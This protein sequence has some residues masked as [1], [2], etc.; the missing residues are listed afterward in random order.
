[1]RRPS[2]NRFLMAS[3]YSEGTSLRA[4]R[5]PEA[6]K[7]T[8]AGARL[9]MSGSSVVCRLDPSPRPPPRSGE[10]SRRGLPPPLR[11]GGGGRG[12]VFAPEAQSRKR[13]WALYNESSLPAIRL[14]RRVCQMK[15]LLRPSNLMVLFAVLIAG[16][17][18]WVYEAT[19]IPARP[20]PLPVERGD[21]EIAW[22]NT[23]T[24]ASAW[25]RFVQAVEEV[26]HAKVGEEAYPQL[27]T[28][29]P[30]V[31]IPL[32]GGRRL[33]FR[34]YKTTSEWDTAYWITALMRRDP[35]PLAILGGNTTDVAIDQARELRQV[36]ESVAAQKRPLLLLT[37][38]TAD[39]VPVSSGQNAVALTEPLLSIYAERTV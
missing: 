22:L 11:F 1:M 13:P 14:V 28:A 21:L 4:V 2:G 9:S 35:P 24:S 36:T 29:V 10:G 37:T 38:A 32:P 3:R 20:V 30:E 17:A 31:A 6:P 18:F 5:S 16:A 25:Q 27:T 8:R 26:T 33:F 39:K 7:M 19:T 12:E 23:A 15:W 34:W